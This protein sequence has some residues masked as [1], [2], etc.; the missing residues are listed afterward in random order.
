M[1]RDAQGREPGTPGYQKPKPK[2]KGLFQQLRERARSSRHKNPAPAPE[3]GGRFKP[4]PVISKAQGAS[5]GGNFKS[6]A[7]NRG[8]AMR[9]LMGDTPTKKEP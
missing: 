2:K 8:A 7:A 9:E 1:P 6:A 3:A 4:A 5:T